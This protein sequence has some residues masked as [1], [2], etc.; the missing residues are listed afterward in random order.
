MNK[1]LVKHA[2]CFL[3]LMVLA[4]PAIVAAQNY[5][6][7]LGVDL[8]NNINVPKGQTDLAQVVVNIINWVLGFLALVAIVIVLI[9]GFEWMTAGGN[10]DKVGTAK[11]RLTYGLIGL[12]IIFLAWA[13]VRFVLNQFSSWAGGT[14]T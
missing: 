3:M 14:T 9:G 12:A 11:K 13:I 10:E 4:M 1:K 7:N 2:L 8:I 5:E 6:E